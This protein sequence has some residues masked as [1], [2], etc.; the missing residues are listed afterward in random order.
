MKVKRIVPNVRF[1]QL[2]DAKRSYGEMLGLEIG[3]DHGWIITFVA[4]DES[5]PQI[6]FAVE[7]KSGAPVPDL[8]VEVDDLREAHRRIVD[9]G[10]QV[11]YGPVTEPWGVERFFVRDPFGRLVNILSH[12]RSWLPTS[13]RS[14]EPR[15]IS[16]GSKPVDLTSY[17]EDL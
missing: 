3:M 9:A 13:E 12:V 6:S 8:S 5:V 17:G 16:S 15:Q 4:S 10:W 2:C 11:E 7:G 14:N 1:D